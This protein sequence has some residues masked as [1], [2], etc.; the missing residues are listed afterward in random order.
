MAEGSDQITE[1]RLIGEEKIV[2]IDY[3]KKAD[4]FFIDIT[5]E[6]QSAKMRKCNKQFED[7]SVFALDQG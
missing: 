4:Q 1:L 2:R 6:N 3:L 5:L 7:R